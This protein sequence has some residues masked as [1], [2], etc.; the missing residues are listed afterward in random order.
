MSG[1]AFPTEAEVDPDLINAGKETVPET[2]AALTSAA[3][4][5]LAIGA[6]RAHRPH[7]LGADCKVIQEEGSSRTG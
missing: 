6:R 7:R 4:T 3:P 1:S 5:R 2:R